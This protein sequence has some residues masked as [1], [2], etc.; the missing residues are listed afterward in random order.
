[1]GAWLKPLSADSLDGFIRES[2]WDYGH[3]AEKRESK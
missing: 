3:D 2:G 1:M